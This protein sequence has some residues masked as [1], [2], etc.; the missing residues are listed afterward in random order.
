MVTD[1]AQMADPRLGRGSVEHWAGQPS[2][3]MVVSMLPCDVP[4]SSYSV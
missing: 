1:E 3:L 2:T 4:V